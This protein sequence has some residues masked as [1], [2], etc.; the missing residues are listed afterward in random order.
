VSKPANPVF[1]DLPT[2]IFTVMSALARE[3]D[4]VNLGQGF[5]DS[6]G[7]EH[8]RRA[9]AEA[10]LA[11]PNQ[12]PP[13]MGTPELRAAVAAHNRRFYG[14]EIDPDS[15]VVITSGATEALADCLLAL[16][17]PGD[18]AILIEPAY[19]AYAP[20]VRAAGATPRFVQLEPPGWQIDPRRLRAAFNSRTKLIVLNSPMNPTG[21]VFDAEELQ[22][23]AELIAEHDVYAVCD[24]VY[25]HLS[26]GGRSHVPL[27][28]LPGMRERCV[29][30]GSAGKTFSLTGWKIGYVTAPRRIA[31]VVAKAHQFVTFTSAPALQHA[32]AVGLSSDDAYFRNLAAEME[33]NRDLLAAG[34]TRAGFR[35]L[36][37]HGTYFM[38]ADFSALDGVRDDMEF[39]KNLTIA[40]KVAAIPV[41]A[42]YDP[43]SPDVPRKLARFCFCKETALLEK[44]VASLVKYFEQ[45]SAGGR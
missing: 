7:P 31:A 21:K 24:E 39:C 17:R 33:C 45:E 37:C 29:R 36:P 19:D 32:V 4:A 2:T 8:V 44:A 27:M 22:L 25:E 43:G 12:Y 3:H 13:S 1:A 9:A 42:F 5:P 38:N 23:I 11:G 18:E 10:I 41:S 16:L 26:F 30:I 34:L 20:L 14:L 28:T 15:E 35:V 6:N 40:A